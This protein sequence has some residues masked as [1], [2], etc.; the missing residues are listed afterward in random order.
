MTQEQTE[1]IAVASLLLMQ[2]S[3]ATNFVGKPRN[4]Q[5]MS[6][7]IGLALAQTREALALL[8]R[9]AVELSES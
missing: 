6:L 5:T 3:F 2:A 4:E 9:V 1:G 7:S 8:E